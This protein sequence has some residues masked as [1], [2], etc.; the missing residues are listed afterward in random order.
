M[1]TVLA[2]LFNWLEGASNAETQPAE[3]VELDTPIYQAVSLD[4]P[5]YQSVTLTTP[6]ED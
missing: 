4:T 6:I 5:M 2:S 3:N 1:W